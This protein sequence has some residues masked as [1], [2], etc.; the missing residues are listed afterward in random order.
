MRDE[1]HYLDGREIKFPPRFFLGAAASP[2]A[3][4]P[5]FQA[6]REHKKVNAGAQFFQSNLVYDL[7]GFEQYM[8]CLD[9]AGVLG[10]THWT[11]FC[12]CQSNTYDVIGAFDVLPLTGIQR[13]FHDGVPSVTCRASQVMS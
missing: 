12:V 11:S 13:P 6:L 3:S 7:E 2:Y 1:G 4:E 9:K 8:E 10:K 5:R